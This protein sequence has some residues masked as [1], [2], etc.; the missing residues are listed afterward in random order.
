MSAP[1][2]PCY[3]ESLP[4][5][6][7]ETPTP[8]DRPSPTLADVIDRLEAKRLPASRQ[9]DLISAVRRIAEILGDKPSHLAADVS[10]LRVRL[11]Q[12]NATEIGVA[13]KTRANL[14][15]NF[16]AALE[17]SGVASRL[18]AKA[19]ARSRAWDELLAKRAPQVRY[20][21]SRL[22]TWAAQEGLEPAAIDEEAFGRFEE[23]VRTR[24]TMNYYAELDTKRASRIHAALIEKR[25]TRAA[26]TRRPAPR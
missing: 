4:V 26:A 6:R 14:R 11:A 13:T 9:R 17:A 22:A 23:A 15:A 25:L 19:A 24:T 12:V 21:L 3:P 18:A 16:L 1:V 8:F 20:G 7:K 2:R 10:A 5:S